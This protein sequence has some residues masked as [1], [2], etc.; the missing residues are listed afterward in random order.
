VAGPNGQP[1]MRLFTEEEV[2][3]GVPE[4]RDPKSPEKQQKFWV[5]RDGKQ[6]RITEDEYREGDTNSSSR[7]Q[8]RPVTSGDAGDLADFDTSLDDLN[9]LRKH[10]S[11][12]G[13]TGILAKAAAKVPYVTQITGWGASAKAKQAMVDRV[14]QVIG[15][16]LEGGVLRKEDEIKYEN[17]LPTMGDANEVVLA[18]LDGLEQAMAQRKSRRMDALQDAGYDVGKFQARQGGAAPTEGATKEIPG[19]PGT[20]QTFRGGKPYRLLGLKCRSYRLSGR[21]WPARQRL[22]S[23]PRTPRTKPVTPWSIRTRLA[24]SRATSANSS[25]RYLSAR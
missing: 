21:K 23:Q 13:D 24:R 20:E 8:G 5:I 18:K 25:I 17:I 1:M 2:A 14:R 19:Y 15:K 10:I 12:A 4:Y 16:V 9:V 22:I 6:L 11:T 3:A 7:E